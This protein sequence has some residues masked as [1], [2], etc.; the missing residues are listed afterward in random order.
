MA[1]AEEV[2][3]EDH[4]RRREDDERRR[5]VA[6]DER[7]REELPPPPHIPQD[8]GHLCLIVAP[9]SG[10]AISKLVTNTA[11]TYDGFP[12]HYRTNRC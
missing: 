12:S 4:E 9:E 10:C 8:F 6:T 7:R 3:E 1:R 2:R 11:K 5:E